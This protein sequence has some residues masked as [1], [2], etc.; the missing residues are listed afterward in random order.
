MTISY[1][2]TCLFVVFC[3]VS[4]ISIAQD[5]P[6]YSIGVL[7]SHSSSIY[8][9]TSKN[10]FFTPF[11]SYES[12]TFFI[13]QTSIGYHISKIIDFSITYKNDFFDPDDSSNVDMQ[14]LDKRK[15]G[16]YAKLSANLGIFNA[17]VEQDMLGRHD[18][19][20]VNGGVNL[21]LFY[22][23]IIPLILKGSLN[24]IYTDKSM[25]N[26]LYSVSEA[27]S[28]LTGNRIAAH[29]SESTNAIRYGLQAILPLT[30]RFTFITVLGYTTYSDDVTASPIVSKSH[31]YSAA[32]IA[33]YKL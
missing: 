19:F 17:T 29:T 31:N 18:G 15:E 32:M 5:T 7:S 27:E 28:D 14:Q 4:T 12:D 16:A 9:Q 3:F 2:N 23:P 6:Q 11:G 25:S 10:E 20:T 24:Y 21:P 30:K 26:Y 1:W 33:T 13:K 22:E 8:K